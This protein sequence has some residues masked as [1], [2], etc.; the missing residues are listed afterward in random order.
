[1]TLD[2][3]IIRI[4]RNTGLALPD[5]PLYTTQ[6]DQNG[7]R[8]VAY[9]FRNPFRFTFRPGTRE[10]WVGDVGWSTWEISIVDTTDSTVDNMGWP[11]YEGNPQQSGYAGFSICQGLYNQGASATVLPYF[12]YHH[13]QV[14]IPGET[15]GT[16]SSSVS[17]LAF[18]RGSGYPASY[19]DALFFADYSRKCVWAMFK[20]ANGLPDTATVHTIMGAAGPVM[21]TTEPVSGDV[22][23]AGY[24]DDRL[25]RI[26]YVGGNLPPTAAIAATPSSGPSPLTVSFTAAGS[27]DPEGQTLTYTWDLDGDG[28]FDDG[29]GLTRS[30]TYSG[31]TSATITARVLVSDPAVNGPSPFRR[32]SSMAAGPPR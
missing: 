27:S 26:R 8:I 19:Q 30:W 25:H 20:G 10:L 12:T 31:A 21:L 11:C 6:S 13:Q 7:K 24:D 17:G 22:L 16:G 29:T 9:G 23:Y 3:A 18:Y 14:I 4:D 15:C 32:S 2:G 28:S 1:M 5:N